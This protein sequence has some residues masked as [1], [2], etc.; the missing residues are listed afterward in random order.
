MG[1]FSTERA[2]KS[3]KGSTSDNSM[4]QL[5]RHTIEFMLTR[6]LGHAILSM[7]RDIADDVNLIRQITPTYN[8]GE[9]MTIVN[10]NL[11]PNR[12]P[13][14][15]AYY[16]LQKLCIQILRMEEIKYG[17]DE[18]DVKGMAAFADEKWGRYAGYAQQVLFHYI[19]NNE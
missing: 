14:Y 9:R 4:M 15:T 10:K 18:K 11:R 6:K 8:Q 16:P 1:L 3:H 19:R 13:Y 2:W 17:F 12:H 7:S 5:I